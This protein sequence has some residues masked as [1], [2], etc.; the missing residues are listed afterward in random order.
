MRYIGIIILLVLF[1]TL[2]LLTGC[3]INTVKEPVTVYPQKWAT[4]TGTVGDPWAGDCL[5]DAYDAC[6]TG[7][8]IYLKAGY[9]KIDTYLEVVKSINIIG[10]GIGRTFII[11]S[12]GNDY[13]IWVN[14]TDYC[15]LKGFTIDG[16]EQGDDTKPCLYI[17][18]CNYTIVE[19]VETKNA[20]SF[21]IDCGYSSYSYFHNIYV[22]D[23]YSHGIHGGSNTEG[24]N[25]NNVYRDI[26]CWDNG[27]NGFD[28]FGY[29]VAHSGYINNNVYDNLQCW[30][31]GSRGIA[32]QY[33][34]GCTLS[35]SFASGNDVNGIWI[36]LCEDLNIH[37]CFV[38]LS[39]EHGIVINDSDNISFVNVVSKNNN[40]E[41]G[42]YINSSNGLRFTSCQ[43]YDD[44]VPPLQEYG[45][46]ITGNK[47]DF[48]ELVNCILMPN[49]KS[50]I[51]NGS[52]AII[53]EAMLVRFYQ[54]EGEPDNFKPFCILLKDFFLYSTFPNSTFI[55]ESFC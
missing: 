6:P 47:V 28:D 29:Q 37:D 11:I 5:N 22:H 19:D 4:G 49:K 43:S 50:A 33:L 3:M 46:S 55:P 15:T 39:E 44:R 18:N 36:S 41:S 38:T 40:G 42:I 51:Y 35:N 10:E 54:L 32:L 23:N 31:N 30:D 26:Y 21:G 14:A 9:Y 1:L 17:Y 8:T 52:G 25:T 2:L 48:V 20:G 7:G 34:K 13:G 24:R 27:N 12:T 45:I 16:D 53:T